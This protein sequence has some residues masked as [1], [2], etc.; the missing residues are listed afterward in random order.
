VERNNN[1]AA[2]RK[3]RLAFSLRV[4]TTQAVLRDREGW[5]GGGVEDRYKL[6]GIRKGAR[7][8]VAYVFD[9]LVAIVIC[10]LYK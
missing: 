1:M 2:V 10:G 4:I 5:G 7:G 9:F 3:L 6:L 8:Y